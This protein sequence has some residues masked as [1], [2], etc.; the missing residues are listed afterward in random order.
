MSC[1]GVFGGILEMNVIVGKSV[2]DEQRSMELC[3]TGYWVYLVI[4]RLVLLRSAHV[5]L[6]IDRVVVAPTSWRS[7]SHS[8]AEHRTT[9]AHAH[10]SIPASIAPSPHSDAVLIDVGLL[11]EPQCRLNLVESLFLS[12][13]KIGAFLKFGSTNSCAS[14]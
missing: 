2:A 4:S 12:K 10:K 8:S 11:A 7:N 6:G 1:L 14:P 13:A 5:T 3:G 9:F